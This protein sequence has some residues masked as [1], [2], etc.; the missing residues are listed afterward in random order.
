[1]NECVIERNIFRLML[2]GT[3]LLI[4]SFIKKLYYISAI[5]KEPD[6]QNCIFVCDKITKYAYGDPFLPEITPKSGYGF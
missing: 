5:D 1:M 3:T 4:N 2:L 6:C